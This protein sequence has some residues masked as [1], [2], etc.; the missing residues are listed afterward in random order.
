MHFCRQLTKKKIDKH[1]C[2]RAGHF[3]EH[4]I[5]RFPLFYTKISLPLVCRPRCR[6][7]SSLGWRPMPES[8][9]LAVDSPPSLRN[10]WCCCECG[11]L[12]EC[13]RR[14]VTRT[15]S[16]GEQISRTLATSSSMRPPDETVCERRHRLRDTGGKDTRCRT[17]G[18][19]P[20]S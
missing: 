12:S 8:R 20:S 19:Q 1:K 14:S 9:E 15:V 7:V 6:L 2:T 17:K 4:H 18:P 3:K 5:K 11:V 16:S 13:G 10:T